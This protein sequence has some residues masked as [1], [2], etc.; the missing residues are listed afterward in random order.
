MPS[1]AD[2]ASPIPVTPSSNCCD[3]FAG[4]PVPEIVNPPGPEPG[5]ADVSHANDAILLS[6]GLGWG[7][8]F[9]PCGKAYFKEDHD[10]GVQSYSVSFDAQ[11][12]PSRS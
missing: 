4:M 12:P 10:D 6:Y 3:G 8:F 1:A 2:K 11:R 5:F 9:T 7:V